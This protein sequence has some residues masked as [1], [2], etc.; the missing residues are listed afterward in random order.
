MG[1]SQ[2]RIIRHAE[3][4]TAKIY[5]PD[6]GKWPFVRGIGMLWDGLGL[7]LRALMWSGE[8]AVQEE[9]G[10]EIDFSISP[11]SRVPTDAR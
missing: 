1:K 7:G 10:E 6:R 4:L 8:V 9:D 11:V 3:L 2:G 5:T